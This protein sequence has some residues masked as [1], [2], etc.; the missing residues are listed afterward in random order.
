[1]THCDVSLPFLKWIR[2]IAFLMHPSGTLLRRKGT[3]RFPML[4][5]KKGPS[6]RRQRRRAPVNALDTM[7]RR[8][9]VILVTGAQKVAGRI[10]LST[11]FNGDFSPI[12]LRLQTAQ[13]LMPG[14]SVTLRN[15]AAG[16][17]Q[18]RV[19]WCRPTP[20][21]ST[22]ILSSEQFMYR[23]ELVYI[24]GGSGLAETPEN[25]SQKLFQVFLGLP[26]KNVA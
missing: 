14:Q 13:P 20:T 24:S 25:Y 11:L 23:A 22:R 7:L 26:N 5:G 6:K 8:V 12:S 10:L 17:V 18:A 9:S 3:T 4:D 16:E 1:M 21:G 19:L 2:V 15:D